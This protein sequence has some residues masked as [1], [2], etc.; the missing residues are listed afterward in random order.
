MEP[1]NNHH[2]TIEAAIAKQRVLVTGHTGFT[3][4]WLALWLR[5]IGCEVTGLA[6]PPVMAREGELMAYRHT[7]FWKPM[8]TLRDKREL[9]EL[10]ANGR[11]PW[12]AW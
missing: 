3:G 10:W 4:C 6:L 2:P 7:G 1:E 11:A 9:E 12:K 5:A 8:D